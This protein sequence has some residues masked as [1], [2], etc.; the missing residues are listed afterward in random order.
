TRRS[1]RS[2]GDASG[3]SRPVEEE[4]IRLAQL[5]RP[6][7]KNRPKPERLAPVYRLTPDHLVEWWHHDEFSP[8]SFACLVPRLGQ[9]LA[10]VIPSEEPDRLPRPCSEPVF[11][12]EGEVRVSD[13]HLPV[14][15]CFR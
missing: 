10:Q 6:R 8:P 7:R 9:K 13:H 15:V 3:D 11:H 12:L 5:D 1:R 2:Q 4:D 14:G